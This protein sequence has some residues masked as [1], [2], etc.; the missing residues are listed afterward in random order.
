MAK[1]V[2]LTVPGPCHDVVAQRHLCPNLSLQDVCSVVREGQTSL[3]SFR[4]IPSRSVKLCAR[5]AEPF[6]NPWRRFISNIKGYDYRSGCLKSQ[7]ANR[8]EC[9]PVLTGQVSSTRRTIRFTK[10]RLRDNELGRD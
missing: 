4:K 9:L 7:V 6:Q 8:L 10:Y 5:L 2:C 1:E 3:A